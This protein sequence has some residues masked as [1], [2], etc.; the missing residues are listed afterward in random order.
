VQQDTE[1]EATKLCALEDEFDNPGKSQHKYVIKN[2]KRV[3]VRLKV[4]HTHF[5]P[6][7]NQ[8]IGSQF[9]E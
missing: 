9:V 1:E 5:A 4:K 3:L 2:P 8:R 7:N 6:L